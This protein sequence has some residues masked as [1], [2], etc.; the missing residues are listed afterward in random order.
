MVVYSLVGYDDGGGESR[1]E[2]NGHHFYFES[3]IYFIIYRMPFSLILS[4]TQPHKKK[5]RS[6]QVE[7]FSNKNGKATLFGNAC[8]DMY[9]YIFMYF[10]AALFL[11]KLKYVHSSLKVFSLLALL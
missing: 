10:R 1:K 5:I 6:S 3:R 9:M 2:K 8:W 11:E 4:L 7:N